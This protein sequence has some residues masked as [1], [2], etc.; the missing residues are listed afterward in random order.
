MASE[1]DVF[2]NDVVSRLMSD[3]SRKDCTECGASNI[4][5]SSH[6]IRCMKQLHPYDA[7]LLEDE[8]AIGST[9]FSQIQLSVEDVTIEFYRIRT[10]YATIAVLCCT[11]PYVFAFSFPG[12]VLLMTSG[13][14]IWW[15][16]NRARFLRGKVNMPQYNMLPQLSRFL[17]RT[18]QRNTFLRIYYYSLII[19]AIFLAMIFLFELFGVCSFRKPVKKGLFFL[20]FVFDSLYTGVLANAI[21]H[22]YKLTGLLNNVAM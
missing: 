2:V 7:S 10:Y 12:T 8:N 16:M 14:M 3:H 22:T 17:P 9:H 19:S 20:R 4:A 1:Q 13:A 11:L 15:L 6:C 21:Y 5:S 18:L